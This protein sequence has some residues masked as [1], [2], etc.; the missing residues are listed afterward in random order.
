MHIRR[1]ADD[2]SAGDLCSFKEFTRS[3]PPCPDIEGLSTE[4]FSNVPNVGVC[5]ED[6]EEDGISIDMA[7]DPRNT[8]NLSLMKKR[9]HEGYVFRP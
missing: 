3:S 2:D 8:H 5:D 1:W 6:Q 4:E 9:E 7:I